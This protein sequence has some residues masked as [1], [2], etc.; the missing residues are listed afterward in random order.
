[1]TMLSLILGCIII[2]TWA[3]H[4]IHT[5]VHEAAVADEIHDKFQEMRLLFEKVL[6]GPH[7]Y[8]IHG[9]KNEKDIF[10]ADYKRLEAATETLNRMIAE[11]KKHSGADTQAIWSTVEQQLFAIEKKLPEFQMV[12]ADIFALELAAKS[13][14]AG[15]HMEKMDS[16]VRKI[17][18]EVRK[19]AMVLAELSAGT[20]GRIHRIYIHV[21]NL[22]LLFG[23]GAVLFAIVLSYYLIQSITRPI[24]N[25]LVAMGRIRDGD[26]GARAK[27]ET[28][29]EIGELAVHFNTMVKELAI[30]QEHMSGILQGSGDGMCVIDKDF[31]ILD[32]NVEM[33]RLTGIPGEKS[34]GKKCYELFSHEGCNTEMCTLTRILGGE[35]RIEAEIIKETQQ[36]RK[37]PV[38]LVA[39]PLKRGGETMG[40]IESYRD[41]TE[42]KQAEEALSESED[43]LRTVINATKDAMISIG[44]DGLI[45][46]FN[47]AAEQMFGHTKEDMIGGPLTPL[48]PEEYRK[49]HNEYVKNYFAVGEPHNAIGKTVELPALRSDGHMFPMEIS[50]SPGRCG[51]KEFVV[52]VARDITERKQAEE[53]LQG[54]AEKLEQSNQE[55]RDFAYVASHDLQ[56]PLRKVTAF[57]DRIKNKCGDA[58]NDQC[59]DYLDR[60]QGAAA[61]MQ[62]LINGLLAFSRVTTKARPFVP[63]DLAK[64]AQEVVSDLEIR[65]AETGGRVEVGDVP[66]IDADPLQMQQ[67][68]Q[69]LIAN[70]LKFHKKGIAPVVKIN[71]KR[72]HGKIEG[73]TADDLC[74]ISVEDN[75]IG[76][77]EKYSDRVFGVFQRLHGRSDYEG[78][79]IGLAVCRRIAERHGGTL[80]AQSTPGQGATFMITLPIAQSKPKGGYNG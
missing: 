43:L 75:G 19:G 46:I 6:M 74:E 39:T 24:G 66:V 55:L 22:L 60:M 73:L 26:L 80:T 8:L 53:A 49:P 30:V 9:N 58:L 77:D 48:M 70:A 38:E 15:F 13:Q 76:F 31:T 12:V 42:R 56:E 62:N 45:N 47:P 71:S 52:A 3:M 33:E 21:Q 65:I 4:Q 20:M 54:F 34:L 36:G 79:G 17:G 44:Q 37:I 18:S 25:L 57:G 29:D 5:G 64:V 32:C 14:K 40:V 11:A 35:E 50:L 59:L 7:D 10:G 16:S 51:G 27:V 78:S 72:V 67:L 2:G 63:V 28:N 23:M 41:I 68:L 61:R 69:N 1:M